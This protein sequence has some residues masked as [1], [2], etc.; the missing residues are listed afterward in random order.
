[1]HTVHQMYSE[2]N[3]SETRDQLIG[4]AASRQVAAPGAR[5]GKGSHNARQCYIRYS[6]SFSLLLWTLAMGN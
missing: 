2:S 5:I 3:V 6:F 1:M 4:N